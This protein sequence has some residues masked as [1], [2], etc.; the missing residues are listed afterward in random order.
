MKKVNPKSGLFKVALLSI[1][2][3]L[4]IAPQISSVLP[5]MYSSFPGVS[6][7][8]V[9]TLSTIPNIGIVIGLII[10]PFLIKL[11]GDRKSVV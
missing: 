4:M 6:R 11:I 10:S 7:A 9:E 3:L 2:L 8:A 1:S 5:L